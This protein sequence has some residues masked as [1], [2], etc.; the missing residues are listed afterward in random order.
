MKVFDRP[1]VYFIQG[2]LTKRI[3]I[4]STQWP[5][6]ERMKNLQIGSPD[7]L[8]FLGAYLGD[9][10]TET[11]LHNLFV[12]A[13]LHG[14]WFEPSIAIEQFILK[15]CFTDLR[16]SFYTYLQIKEGNISLEQALKLGS[17]NLAEMYEKHLAGLVAGIRF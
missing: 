17:Q 2:K 16:S 14:E 13:R 11:Q 4:G 1:V 8:I 9:N 5:I 6:D 7:E 12:E 15:H 3:K 10:F